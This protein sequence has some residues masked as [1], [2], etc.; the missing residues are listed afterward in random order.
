ME[1]YTTAMNIEHKKT[2]L[3]DNA[4][5][6][7]RNRAA[8]NKENLKN[9]TPKE[10]FKFFID[11]YSKAS[12]VIVILLIGAISL[13]NQTVFNRSTCVLSVSCVND[14]QIGDS[15]TA[16]E[17]L[18]EYLAIENKNDYAS[19][20]YYST[21]DPNMNMAFVAH[22]A[23]GSL[24]IILCSEEYFLAGCEQGMYADLRTFLTEEQYALLADRMIEGQV[25]KTDD[26]GNVVSYMDPL[27]FG[28]NISDSAR[29]QEYLGFGIDPILCV[30]S[31]SKNIDNVIKGITWFTGV[32][33][34]VPEPAAE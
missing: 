25:A 1:G 6:Y 27:S 13:L 7:S 33:L 31:T 19:I 17:A 15:D 11:Y 5:I 23:T 14:I 9:M 26:M 24:D 16:T 21:D 12:L 29:F 2:A 8:A 10:K 4:S 32:E 20:S 34:P 30:A 3:D 28:I 22:L 18:E